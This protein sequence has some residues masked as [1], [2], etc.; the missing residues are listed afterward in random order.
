V[1]NISRHIHILVIVVIVLSCVPIAIELYRE[2][3]KASKQR[4]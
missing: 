4:T 3:R 2:R 1:P